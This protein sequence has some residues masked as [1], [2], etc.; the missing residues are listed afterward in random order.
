MIRVISIRALIIAATALTVSA[1]GYGEADGGKTRLGRLGDPH[2]AVRQSAMDALLRD[3]SLTLDA[4]SDLYRRATDEEQRHRL[5]V[6]A[7]HHMLRLMAVDQF[8]DGRRGVI[9]ILMRPV[10]IDS[11]DE[12]REPAVRVTAVLA[13]FPGYAHLRVGD[14]I[15]SLDRVPVADTNSFGVMVKRKNPGAL[16]NLTVLRERQ[17]VAI[18]FN[19]LDYCAMREMYDLRSPRLPLRAAFSRKWQ[20]QRRSLESSGPTRPLLAIDTRH[21]RVSRPQMGSGLSDGAAPGN[22][23]GPVER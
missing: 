2:F 23:G 16:V 12:T 14:V 7:R 20:Q 19:L 22:R 21:V 3:D 8:R 6:V 17:R 4:I 9:G 15:L 13:G 11:P 1:V 18:R 10:M 5:L